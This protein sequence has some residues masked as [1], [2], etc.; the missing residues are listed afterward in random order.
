MHMQKVT[1][2][3]QQVASEQ[4]CTVPTVKTLLYATHEYKG[5]NNCRPS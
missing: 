3:E 5:Q 1:R 2:T 4:F